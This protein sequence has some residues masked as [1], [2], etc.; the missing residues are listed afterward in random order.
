MYGCSLDWAGK[1]IERVT[2]HSLEE[3]M[4]KNIFE[5][6]G[7]TSIT[8]FPY[9]NQ[10]L[11]EKI[12]GMSVRTPDGQLMPY[13]EPF[14]NAGSKDA[15]GGHGAFAKMEDYLKVQRSILANDGKLLKPE[16][17][18]M[19]FS[20]QLTPELKQSLKDFR[21]T[22]MAALFIGD[23]DPAIESDWGIGGILYLQDDVGRRKKGTLNW[24]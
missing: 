16:S 10:D 22:P 15:F 1:L 18:E 2:G 9:E 19:M 14:I 17:V 12:P 7:A 3:Y 6:L 23:N 4:K 20:P 8:F 24:G 11:R 5:P 21:Y 13:G